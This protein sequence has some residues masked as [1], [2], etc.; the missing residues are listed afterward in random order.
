MKTKPA[1]EILI[2][3][4][5]RKDLSFLE[6]MFPVLD[7]D[8]YQLLV[9][10]QTKLDEDLVSHDKRIRVINSREFGLS[11]S[12]NLA[13]ENAIG[14]I[15]L[16]A[17]DDIEYLPGFKQIILKAYETYPEASLISFQFLDENGKLA[18]LYPRY[19]GY[20]KSNKRP[21]SSVEISIRKEDILQNEIWF[22]ERFGIGAT[23]PCSEEQVLRHQILKKGLGVA[24]VSE[25]ICIHT[26]LTSGLKLSSA[27]ILEATTAYK[28]I[29]YNNLVYLWLV[30]YVFFLFRHT[31]I[32]FFGQIRAYQTGVKAISKL[33]RLRNED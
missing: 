2:S 4:M 15:L 24:Y 11:K 27:S 23:F 16:I 20:I 14:D 30:K 26:G 33:K 13:I 3:T 19:T 5:N 29:Q 10:N 21:L 28:F 32:S 8:Q 18:K 25:P 12:R 1:L 22:D 31:H 17:D 7:L 9:I 6:K